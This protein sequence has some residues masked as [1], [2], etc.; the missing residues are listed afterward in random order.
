MKE[1][2]AT[3]FLYSSGLWRYMAAA[4]PLRGSI[5]LG[6]VNNWGKKDSKIFDKSKNKNSQLIKKKYYDR[7]ILIFIE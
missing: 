7:E 2:P 5:G 6:Y 3:F 1:I 4:S